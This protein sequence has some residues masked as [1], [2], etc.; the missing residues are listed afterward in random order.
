MQQFP[1]VEAVI[2]LIQKEHID[3]KK[4]IIS[5][6]EHENLRI[7]Q[8]H[9]PAI[10]INALIG[11][12]AIAGNHWADFEFQIYNANAAYISKAQIQAARKK[13]CKVNLH[14]VNKLSNMKRFIN[15]GVE[16]LITDYPQ[17]LTQLQLNSD[18]S[19]QSQRK[20]Q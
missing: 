14:T 1:L 4:I 17:L 12:N 15:W 3:Q 5:S 7:A 18:K 16:T 8:K 11:R 9:A 10:E 13:G 2:T 6:F 20:Q 19:L